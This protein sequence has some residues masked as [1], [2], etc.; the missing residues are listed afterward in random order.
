MPDRPR[1]Y[2]SAPRRPQP[3]T[4]TRP[5][6]TERGYDRRWRKARAA[7]LAQ[8]PLCERCEREGRVTEA[9]HVH[10]KDGLGPTGPRGFDPTNLEA[11]C[12]HHHNQHTAR[13][14][15]RRGNGLPQ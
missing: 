10:H 6:A 7:Y 14:R 13:E 8:F 15:W 11:L 2:R 3:R 5:D 1:Q 9:E 12:P 4:D